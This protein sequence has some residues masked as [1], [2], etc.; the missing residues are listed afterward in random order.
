MTPSPTAHND[1]RQADALAT[2]LGTRGAKPKFIICAPRY[3]ETSGGSIALH[4]LAQLLDA[5]GYEALLWPLHRVK[6]HALPFSGAWWRKYIYI[7]TRLYRPRYKTLPGSTLRIAAKSDIDDSIV[8]YPDIVDGN[9]LRARR[10][11][12]WFLYHFSKKHE[13]SVLDGE[14][15]FCYQEAFNRNYERMKYGGTLHVAH[16]LLDIYK[17]TNFGNRSEVCYMVRKGKSRP[18]LPSFRGK[19]VVDGMDHR[20]LAKVFNE[21]KYCYFYDAYTGYSTYAA[22]CGCI[23]VIVPA[24]G[25]E[26]NT[27]EPNGGRKPGIAYG[28]EDIPYAIKTRPLLLQRLTDAES[29]SLDSVRNF[30]EI[31]KRHFQL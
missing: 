4:K 25:M 2:P 29:K 17:Q 23:P 11:V 24:P 10:Y 1:A 9:P 26:R 30:V 20:S 31:I 16:W 28:E 14:L 6:L 19:V 27:W 12:R 22:A 13:K 7:V 21:K 18:D 5:L 3:S 15:Y 8:I